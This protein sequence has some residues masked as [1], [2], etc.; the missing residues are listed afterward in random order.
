MKNQGLTLIEAII[1]LF[2]ISVGLVG[3]FV[4]FQKIINY[5][6]IISSRLI[7]A[8]LSQEGIEIVR[9][10][11][12]SYWLDNGKKWH[13]FLDEA[14][15]YCSLL[16][17]GCEVDYEHAGF[18]ESNGN[19]LRI[20]GEGIYSY[21][22]NGNETR[23]KRKIIIECNPSDIKSPAKVIVEVSWNEKGQDYQTKVQG[24]L[25]PWWSEI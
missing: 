7:S 6:S 21:N 16:Q 22:V 1:S 15:A 3:F 5:N 12:D 19:Y 11:R 10:I 25:Y 24:N 14:D 13:D 9:N 23:F 8:Y 17:G 4:F 18:I 20:D 2:L